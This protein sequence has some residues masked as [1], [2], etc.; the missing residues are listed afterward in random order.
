[1]RSSRAASHRRSAPPSSAEAASLSP[2]NVGGVVSPTASAL[3]S[4]VLAS[5]RSPGS[6]A[7]TTMV[8]LPPGDSELDARG[9]G[10]RRQHRGAG[11][12]LPRVAKRRRGSGARRAA[13]RRRCRRARTR[14][15]SRAHDPARRTPPRR[16]RGEPGPGARAFA[17]RFGVARR[18]RDQRAKE[19]EGSA[20]H[21]ARQHS[22]SPVA[23]ASPTTG[24]KTSR[25]A[26]RRGARRAEGGR[27]M[28]A[29]RDPRAGGGIEPIEGP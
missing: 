6:T 8:A 15:A 2:V 29:K 20:V 25:E 26:P 12:R 17:G 22:L 5:S 7:R 14:A 3:F 10:G 24:R 16:T 11:G 21:P 1:M 23:L 9:P 4:T 28:R 18:T 27:A 19:Q 13:R